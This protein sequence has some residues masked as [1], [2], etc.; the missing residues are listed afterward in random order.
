M[1]SVSDSI[2]RT[3]TIYF[4][5]SFVSSG[6]LGMMKAMDFFRI[7]VIYDFIESIRNAHLVSSNGFGYFIVVIDGARQI[8]KTSRYTWR[9]IFS[10]L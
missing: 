3:E 8:L 7:W 6:A 9:T 4:G 2:S 10:V 5:M 1:S